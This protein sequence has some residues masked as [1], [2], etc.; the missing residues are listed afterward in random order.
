M[1]PISELGPKDEEA[2]TR[3]FLENDRP[4]ITDW[5]RA[6][7]MDATSAA[8]ICHG[9]RLTCLTFSPFLDPSGMLRFLNLASPERVGFS[10]GKEAFHRR[11]DCVRIE[12]S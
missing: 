3:F 12:A 5:F 7:P 2:L 11:A 6:F 1:N 9:P 10:N 4:E 8:R